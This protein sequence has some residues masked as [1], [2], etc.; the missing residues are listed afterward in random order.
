[1]K[2][3]KFRIKNTTVEDANN[4]EHLTMREA[5]RDTMAEEMRKTQKYLFR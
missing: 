1:M 4:E 3:I 5:L 2:K